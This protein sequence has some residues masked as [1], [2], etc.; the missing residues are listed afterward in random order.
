[1]R[2]LAGL[3]V[4]PLLLCGS[5][6][7]WATTRTETDRSTDVRF[8]LD[9]RTLTAEVLEQ[10]ITVGTGVREDLY[11]K[12]VRGACGT[13]FREHNIR[14]TA[15]SQ[16]RRWPKGRDRF[17]FHFRRDISRR[18]KW[19]L[20]EDR[21]GGDVALVR[22]PGL[23]VASSALQPGAAMPVEGY[24][25]YF[26]LRDRHG[27]HPRTF[28]GDALSRQVRPGRYSLRA[29]QRICDGNCGQLDAPTRGCA[30]RVTI[31][32]GRTVRARVNVNFSRGCTLM[33]SSDRPAVQRAARRLASRRTAGPGTRVPASRWRARC[34]LRKHDWRCRVR[35]RQ[36]GCKGTLDVTGVPRHFRSREFALRCADGVSGKVEGGPQPGTG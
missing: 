18:A 7:A 35:S 26:R 12:R 32:S 17:S 24:V 13:S 15:V 8:T 30:R 29:Y 27:R 23:L 25:N 33:L 16:L 21:T 28:R 4:V 2:R 20:L 9:G 34:A 36:A 1:M 10:P 6:I 31:P 14:R 11:G 22:F 5:S 19:C 3:A